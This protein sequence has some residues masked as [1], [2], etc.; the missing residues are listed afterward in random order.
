MENTYGIFLVRK[1]KIL[2]GHPTKASGWTIMKGRP[3]VNEKPVETALREFKEESGIDLT[4]YTNQLVFLGTE[5]YKFKHKQIHA[6]LLKT[7]TEFPEP[8]CESIVTDRGEPFFPELDA[9][10]WVTYDEAL[11]LVFDSQKQLL[12]KNKDKFTEITSNE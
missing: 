7:D 9:F 6:Y 5:L 3:E 1:N 2:I 12:M 4:P 10:K 11:S 8:K